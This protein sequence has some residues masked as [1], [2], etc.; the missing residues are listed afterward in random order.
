[1]SH[2]SYT[3]TRGAER[4]EPSLG[5]MTLAAI[6]VLRENENGYVLFVEGG[7]IDHAHHQNL[8]SA[9]YD[10]AT[11][12]RAL[13]IYRRCT[14][15]SLVPQAHVALS[16]TIAFSRAVHVAD[17]ATN[18]K[19]TLIVV[20]SD[21]SHT[22][23][24]NGYPS[25]EDEIVGH[26]GRDGDAYSILSYANGPSANVRTYEKQSSEYGKW[27]KTDANAY[28]PR[29]E[30]T[31]RFP[32]CPPRGVSESTRTTTISRGHARPKVYPNK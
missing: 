2:M 27:R 4:D 22:M 25:R 32:G 11:G 12:R 23:T 7:R 17:T 14:R 28:R 19:S 20:T 26:V 31:F 3:G 10:G 1:M 8:V 9:H 29:D 16:E 5:D 18:P 21:H 24:I 13:N 30:R 6:Q 15:V